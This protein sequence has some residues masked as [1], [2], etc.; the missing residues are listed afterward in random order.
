MVC[1]PAYQCNVSTSLQRFDKSRAAPSLVRALEE[2]T[3][4]VKDKRVLIPGCGYVSS[5]EPVSLH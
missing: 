5:F 4:S 3:L 1:V 2:D